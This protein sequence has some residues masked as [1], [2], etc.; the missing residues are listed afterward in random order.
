M[1]YLSWLLIACVLW[2]SKSPQ[3]IPRYCKRF[4][5]YR[6]CSRVVDHNTWNFSKAFEFALMKVNYYS[7][8]N[9]QSIHLIQN[10]S[11]S[12]NRSQSTFSKSQECAFAVAHIRIESHVETIKW[13]HNCWAF[14]LQLA[15]V[16]VY[17]V[18]LSQYYHPKWCC[19]STNL[20]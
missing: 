4:L 5:L 18:F 16:F 11:I 1:R 8:L 12:C 3:C 13:S 6:Q 9:R 7:S 19:C 10:Q 2:S 20:Q 17:R 15:T 14:S